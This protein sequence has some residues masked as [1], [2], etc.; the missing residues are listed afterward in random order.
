MK[1]T[2]YILAA[3]FF[4]FACQATP[5]DQTPSPNKSPMQEVKK[6]VIEKVTT[7]S[8]VAAGIDLS[9][10]PIQPLKM[11]ENLNAKKVK[12]GDLLFHDTKL[13]KDNT[14]SCASCHDLSKGGTDL[15]PVSLGVGGVKGPIN[16][17]T[18][19]NSH[20]NFV[21]FWDGRAK[22]LEEQAEGPVHNPLEMGSNWPEVIKKLNENEEYK[23]LFAELYS[24][25]I[26]GKNI[27]NAIAE[28]EKSLVTVNSRFD[29][30]LLGKKDALT[31]LEIQG[32]EYFEG[33]GCVACHNGPNVGGNSFQ[34]FGLIK[35]YFADK[36][37]LTEADNGRF[38]VTKD[39]Q[40]KHKFKVPSL[41]VAALTPPYFHD[42][43]AQTLEEAIQTMAKYQL[44]TTLSA[45][46]VKA[47]VAFLK[48]LVGEYNGKPLLTE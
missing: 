7:T 44:N 12:L 36:K 14:L 21:Q 39:P 17:P 46:E 19:F 1:Q 4:L 26:T 38:N 11:P 45:E 24:D 29:Q 27:A 15:V 25:G 5:V 34:K 32:Y 23:K 35:D 6:N 16:S 9:G 10:S 13:S 43:S 42:A 18:V 31:A 2:L 33:Y 40:D 48:S 20:Y 8:S 22:D 37:Q 41:R 28:F 30:Y 3:H 47:I